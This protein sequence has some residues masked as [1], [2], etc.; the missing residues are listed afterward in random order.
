MSVDKQAIVSTSLDGSEVLGKEGGEE[1]S[2][3]L[4]K[5]LVIVVGIF[6]NLGQVGLHGNR[7]HDASDDHVVEHDE[8]LFVLLRYRQGSNFGQ[9]FE[10][11]VAERGHAKELVNG[12]ALVS[13]R[14][15]G[16]E[17]KPKDTH[18]VVKD[19]DNVGFK[20]VAQRN[21]VE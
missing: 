11:D 10:R 12:K 7:L 6:V 2:E 1:K 5:L 13:E 3:I 21:P 4:D 14:F 9:A 15:P 18:P 17:L 8:L 16:N 19:L 20:D